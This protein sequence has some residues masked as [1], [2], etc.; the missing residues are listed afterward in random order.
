[1]GSLIFLLSLTFLLSLFQ[2]SVCG[3]NKINK[4]LEEFQ[5]QE[6]NLEE[7]RFKKKRKS[8]ERVKLLR[9]EV[10]K[11]NKKEK[12]VQLKN[13]D[14]FIY[15]KLCIATGGS[16]KLIEDNNPFVI[17]IRDTETVNVPM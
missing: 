16:P 6:E 11:L 2:K 17:G 9:G 1:M 12:F 5:V 10:V 7:Y 3:V 13:N 15:D 14:K 4:T 8:G